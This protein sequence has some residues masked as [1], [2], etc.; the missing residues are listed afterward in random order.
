MRTFYTFDI[1][2]SRTGK[3]LNIKETDKT[4]LHFI[5]VCRNTIKKTDL[6][7]SARG[8][9]LTFSAILLA[10]IYMLKAKL[11]ICTCYM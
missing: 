5:T 6:D 8:V 2:N 10:T 4:C 1:D 7:K 11:C 9:K 3:T